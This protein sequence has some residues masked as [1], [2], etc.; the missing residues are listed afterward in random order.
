MPPLCEFTT[1]DGQPLHGLLYAAAEPDARGVLLVHGVGGSFYTHPY[2]QLA[3]ALAGHGFTVL[4]ANTRGHDWVTRG[5]NGAP[6]AG[7]SFER[8]RDCLLDIDAG[9]ACLAQAG[10]GSF[11]VMGHSLGAVKS[12]FYQG[13]RRRA[14]VAAVVSCSAPKLFYSTRIQEQPDFADKI[15]RAQQ[16]LAEGR[17]SELFVATAGSAPGLFSAQTYVDKYGPAEDTDLRRVA[18]DLGCRV[19]TIAGS[20]EFSPSFVPYAKELA[21]LAHGQCEIIQ[22]APHSYDG[23]EAQIAT[24]VADWL[25]A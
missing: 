22:G 23:Y 19:L 12:V 18:A 9:L 15:A 10:F 1:A 5:S 4:A 21:D 16:L 13:N 24:V 14:D 20:A 3:E 7:A 11:V 6:S 25:H 2:P 8:I 17:G